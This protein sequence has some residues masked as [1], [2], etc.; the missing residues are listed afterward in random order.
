MV[1]GPILYGFPPGAG[2]QTAAALPGVPWRFGSDTD[3]GDPAAADTLWVVHADAVADFRA[4][5]GGRTLLAVVWVPR[6]GAEP[7][8]DW[9]EDFG[10]VIGEGDPDGERSLVRH[11]RC[12]AAL[13]AG[14]AVEDVAADWF[15]AQAGPPSEADL[16]RLPDWFLR[17]H[18]ALLQ[19]DPDCR[20]EVLS[21][22]Q[23][24]AAALRAHLFPP[25]GVVSG[26]LAGADVPGIEQLAGRSPYFRLLVREQAE[27]LLDAGLVDAPVLGARLASLGVD[28]PRPASPPP[29][30]ST[31]APTGP[32][33]SARALR[34]W[35][36]DL[37]EWLAALPSA[38]GSVT[39]F[40]DALTQAAVRQAA[41]VP[42]LG[43]TRGI[44][45]A[46]EPT[47]PTT[48]E[49]TAAAA[50][51]FFRQNHMI[52]FRTADRTA[53]LL[54]ARTGAG[55]EVRVRSPGMVTP[56]RLLFVHDGGEVLTVPGRLEDSAPSAGGPT[57]L[58]TIEPQHL[59]QVVAAGATQ[60]EIIF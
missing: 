27:I 48:P 53:T 26:W 23:C 55:L 36:L 60:L 25:A 49:Q 46:G 11:A 6:A 54:L 3:F 34:R 50:V 2:G 28:P 14:E 42:E 8:P 47:A 18:G 4:R 20:A 43:G 22:L 59:R 32:G 44:L 1:T 51:A 58:V 38:V 16:E 24:R 19:S 15:L 33:A 12:P 17:D 29:T 45:R 56:P 52:R 39:D 40:A 5:R 9:W 13:R 7:P 35:M 57:G 37:A 41:L 21:R 30:P 10:A 31:P